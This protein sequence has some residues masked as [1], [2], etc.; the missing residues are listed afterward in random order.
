MSQIRAKWPQRYSASRWVER[1][2]AEDI[3]ITHEP[4][5]RPSKKLACLGTADGNSLVQLQKQCPRLPAA[6]HSHLT[7]QRSQAVGCR[8]ARIVPQEGPHGRVW[9]GG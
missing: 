8:Q 5:C 3:Y 6:G 9:R 1:R 7:L 4:N 2:P